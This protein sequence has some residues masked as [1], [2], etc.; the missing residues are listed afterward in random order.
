MLC[1]WWVQKGVIHY[2]LLNPGETIT[3]KHYRIQLMRLKAAV[4]EIRQECAERHNRIILQQ[5]NAQP[6]IAKVVKTNLV[7]LDWE[8]NGNEID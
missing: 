5:D 2:E 7:R 1:I 3:G 6:H 4:K 8:M